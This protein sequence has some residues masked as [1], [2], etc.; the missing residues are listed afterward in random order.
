M[1]KINI[2]SETSGGRDRVV[3]REWLHDLQKGSICIRTES[4]RNARQSRLLSAVWRIFRNLGELNGNDS[5]TAVPCKMY[6]LIACLSAY[7]QF[8]NKC[9][10]V[11]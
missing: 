2:V 9:F 8:G 10:Y 7:L 6:L 4:R 1:K 5:S 11:T 3:R